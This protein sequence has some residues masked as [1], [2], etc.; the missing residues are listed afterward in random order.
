MRKPIVRDNGQTVELDLHGAQIQEAI[1]LLRRTLLVSVDRGRSSVK[2]VHGYSTSINPRKSTSIRDEL[3]ALLDE[4]SLPEVVSQYRLAGST[5]LI[6]GQA[7][8]QDHR[9][10]TMRDIT[11]VW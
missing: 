3:H 7:H 11:G 10:I 9:R 8:A 5:M 2:V 4:E 6:L 1:I